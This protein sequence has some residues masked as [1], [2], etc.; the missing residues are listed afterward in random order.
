MEIPPLMHF[1]VLEKFDLGRNVFII[2]ISCFDSSALFKN[3]NSPTVI[4]LS[5]ITG[6]IWWPVQTILMGL[7]PDHMDTPASG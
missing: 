3:T 5:R 1:H 6:I 7:Q 2:T 4:L